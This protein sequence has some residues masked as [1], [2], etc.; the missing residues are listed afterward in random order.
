MLNHDRKES[1]MS[2]KMTPISNPK[3]QA[4]FHSPSFQD[5]S[6]S[7]PVRRMVEDDETADKNLNITDVNDD[8]IGHTSNLIPR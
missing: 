8:D 4:N 2:I 3:V 7:P 5:N 6:Q 1:V